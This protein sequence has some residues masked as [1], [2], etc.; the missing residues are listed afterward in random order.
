MANMANLPAGAMT[1]LCDGP[2]TMAF[3]DGRFNRSGSVVCSAG[4]NSLVEGTATIATTGTYSIEGD[5]LV[6]SDTANTGVMELA[7]TN[8]PF[9]DSWGN[10]SATYR[11][12]GDVLEIIFSDASVGTVTQ[13]YVRAG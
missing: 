5:R 4:L 1:P 12:D 10:G 8:V 7:G 9:P 2:I 6:V 3:A 11:I 13:K